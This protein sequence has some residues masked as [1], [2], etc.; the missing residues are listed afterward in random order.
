[1]KILEPGVV[2]D[3]REVLHGRPW[4]VTPVRVVHDSGEVLVTYLAEGTPL[5]F[6]EHPFGPHPWSRTAQWLGTSL[7]QVQ[8]L[9]DAHAVWGFYEKGVF[10]GWYIN[11]QAPMRRWAQG[12]DTVDHGVDIWIPGGGSQW[13]WKDLGDVTELVRVGRLTPQEADEV[14]AETE[15]VAAA[16]DKGERWWNRWTGWMPD[17][18]WPVPAATASLARLTD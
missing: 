9:G 12:F 1:M 6:P 2:I 15:R 13:Q 7:L 4:L 8:R 10:T 18:S 5:I 16:L 17:P 14:W 11:F 3:R